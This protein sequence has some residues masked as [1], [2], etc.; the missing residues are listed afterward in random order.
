MGNEDMPPGMDTTIYLVEKSA[1]ELGSAPLCKKRKKGIESEAESDEDKVDKIYADSRRL[2]QCSKYFEMCMNKR[3]AQSDPVSTQM[4]FCLE[5]QTDVVY[6]HDCFSRMKPLSFRKPI[7]SVE[8]CLELIKVASQIVYQELVDL[9]MNY[10]AST[11]WS[12]DEEDQIRKFCEFGHIFVN[13]EA[14]GDLIGRLRLYLNEKERQEE[15]SNITQ[16]SILS[17]YL[18][19]I[20]ARDFRTWSPKSCQLFEEAFRII[21]FSS[22]EYAQNQCVTLVQA[23]IE[24]VLSSFNDSRGTTFQEDVVGFCWLYG[25]LR[26]ANTAQSIVE[27][28]LKERE[29]VHFMRYRKDLA[30]EARKQWVMLICSMLQDV[31]NGRLFLS[32]SKR[33]A[34]FMDWN[35]LFDTRFQ[36][37]YDDDEVSELFTTYIMTFQLHEQQSMIS[38]WEFR[39]EDPKLCGT[40]EFFIFD[41]YEKWMMRLIK[42]MV[43]QCGQELTTAE[44]EPKDSTGQFSQDTEKL[45]GPVIDSSCLCKS[46]DAADDGTTTAHVLTRE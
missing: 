38:C 12:A 13:P 22:N 11:P 23:A 3:W 30:G 19:S 21:V 34:L 5:L 35:W 1:T 36:D 44:E 46:N 37:V 45:L 2:R 39:N 8:H 17:H 26:S 7:P 32:A 25:L 29:V 9:G 27:S 20:L 41:T 33:C 18:E 24:R 43:P 15:V 10:L 31:L 28:L 40:E 14:H 6:Y 4:E 16:G 42:K